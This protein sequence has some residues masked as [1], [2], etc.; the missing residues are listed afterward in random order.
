M[1]LI[2]QIA[3]LPRVPKVKESKQTLPLIHTDDT[4]QDVGQF[5]GFST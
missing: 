3:K 1:T 2:K 5:W 4:D